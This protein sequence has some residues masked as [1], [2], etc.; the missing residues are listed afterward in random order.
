MLRHMLETGCRASAE[1]RMIGALRQAAEKAYWDEVS[2]G[3]NESGAYSLWRR[4]S[5][6]VNIRL[7]HRW[8]PTE[9]A[10][11]VL[12][13]DLFD[14]VVSEGLYPWLANR[15]REV[16]GLD[17]SDHVVASAAERYPDLQAQSGD[18]RALA[19]EAGQFDCIV[20][21][22]SLDHFPEWE[23]LEAALGELFRVLK[24]G[25]RLI[26]TLDNPQNPLLWLRGVLPQSWLHRTGLVPYYVGKSMGRRKLVRQLEASGFRVLETRG[27]MHCPRVLSVRRAARMQQRSITEQKAFLESLDRW[28]NLAD[29][30]V[31][32]FT[33][34]FVAAMA[35]KP[36]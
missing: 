28:E 23:Q 11:R 1:L 7:L 20:S 27:I 31:A 30:P 29:S 6:Q 16:T 8:F 13:T 3:F 21:N 12:K 15:S 32:Y 25:G 17:L 22:S 18:L 35:E 34:H 5:D 14:E 4:H 24:P 19:F 26:L 33:A 2:A 9:G 36:A 10:S